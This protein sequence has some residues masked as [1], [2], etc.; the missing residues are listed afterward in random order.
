M[1]PPRYFQETSKSGSGMISVSVKVG[2]EPAIRCVVAGQSG[3]GRPPERQGVASRRAG[4]MGE[5]TRPGLLI[6][7]VGETGYQR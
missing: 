3:K 4:L 2:R 1:R 6:G 7:S 5:P